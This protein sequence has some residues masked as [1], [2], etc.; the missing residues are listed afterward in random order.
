[1]VS[2][3]LTDSRPSTGW[4]AV[5]QNQNH[6][7]YTLLIVMQFVNSVLCPY[8]ARHSTAL[9][10]AVIFWLIVFVIIITTSECQL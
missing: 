5:S 1:M 9:H 4:S 2:L 3:T 7:K 10:L 6:Q 8:S